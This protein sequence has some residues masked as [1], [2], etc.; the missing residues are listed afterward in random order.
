MSELKDFLNGGGSL[1]PQVSDN[2]QA[3]SRMLPRNFVT[4]GDLSVNQIGADQKTGITAGGYLYDFW[5]YIFSGVTGISTDRLSGDYPLGFYSSL[6]TTFTT[7]LAS[8]G[9]GVYVQIEQPIENTYA[10]NLVGKEFTVSFWV[11]ASV[12]GTYT[13]SLRDFSRSVSYVS[14]YTINTANTWEKKVITVVGGLPNSVDWG[15]SHLRLTFAP[16]SGSNFITSTTNAW[17]SGSYFGV[18]G[19]P[20]IL[21]TAN[22]SFNITGVKLELGPEATAFEFDYPEE[23]VRCQRR[24]QTFTIQSIIRPNAS[25]SYLSQTTVLPVEML[26]TPTVSYSA[27]GQ[28]NRVYID[29]VGPTAITSGGFAPYPNRVIT[30]AV[31]SV[32]GNN[33][34]AV[35]LVLEAQ[36]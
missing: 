25:S 14:P 24:Y 35:Q 30:D 21:A 34:W 5:G 23:L 33:W 31:V 9:S 1:A 19:M 18:A 26:K 6:K 32:V 4:N 27:S 13:I 29:A 36:L 20:N 28:A 11:K 15:S 16:V 8:I 12:A 7:S 17:I 22:N 3:I 10:R 2:T